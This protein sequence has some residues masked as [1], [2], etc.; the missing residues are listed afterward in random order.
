MALHAFPGLAAHQ[1][2]HRDFR[3]TVTK[4]RRFIDA[5]QGSEKGVQLVHSLL[6]NWYV[7]HIKGADQ[8]YVT[9]FRGQGVTELSS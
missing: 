9:F 5:H 8:E 1:Q 6:A 7:Q 3:A 2:L 4:A